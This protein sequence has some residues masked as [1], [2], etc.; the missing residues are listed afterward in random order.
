MAALASSKI[1]SV[2]IALAHLFYNVTGILLWYPIPLMRRINL[3]MATWLGMVTRRWRGFPPV[4]IAIVFFGLPLV[5]LGISSC[6]EQHNKGFMALG[7]FLALILAMLLGYLYYLWAFCNGKSKFQQCI[8][9]RERRAA[10]NRPLADDMD[11]VKVDLEWC[12][13]EIGRNKDFASRIEIASARR[14][15]EG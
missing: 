14:M 11:F 1:D 7:T 10:A 3:R 4:F 6:F 12:R 5:M 8:R 2:Q 15:E 9:R 13:N